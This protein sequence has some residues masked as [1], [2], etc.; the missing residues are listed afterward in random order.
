MQTH[1]PGQYPLQ[2]EPVHPPSLPFPYLQYHSVTQINFCRTSCPFNHNNICHLLPTYGNAF[3]MSGMSCY[4]ISKIVFCSS[5]FPRNFSIY[6]DLGTCMIRRLSAESDS[7]RH[8]G[9]DSGSFRLHD[10]RPPHF[11]VRPSVIKEFSAIFWD[12]NGADPVSVLLK[13]CGKALLPADFFLHLT[14][15]PVP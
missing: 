5:Y 8:I 12:L 15:F 3:L 13:N 11:T 2:A 4:L 10:L 9:S 1:R 14:W 7:Y 6:N